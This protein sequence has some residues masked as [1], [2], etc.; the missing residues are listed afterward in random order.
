MV[1]NKRDGKTRPKLEHKDKETDPEVKREDR[2]PNMEKKRKSNMIDPKA[3]HKKRKDESIHLGSDSKMKE[4]RKMVWK[5]KGMEKHERKDKTNTKGRRTNPDK[6]ETWTISEDHPQRDQKV[7]VKP[8]DVARGP[9]F[10]FERKGMHMPCP[11]TLQFELQNASEAK[12]F[13]NMRL[14]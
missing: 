3:K 4:W 2:H 8:H 5:Y 11:P 9:G 12:H 10:A 13:Q 1:G 6:D 14:R 7:R